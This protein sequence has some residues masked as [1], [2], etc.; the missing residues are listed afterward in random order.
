MLA[1]ERV[2]R[3]NIWRLQVVA[4]FQPSTTST[5][6]STTRTEARRAAETELDAQLLE[7]VEHAPRMGRPECQAPWQNTSEGCSWRA[8]R[9]R[10]PARWP[11]PAEEQVVL[12]IVRYSICGCAS[13][14]AR[15][16]RDPVRDLIDTMYC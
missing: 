4:L 16:R 14:I 11:G 7:P 5:V 10:R 9:W 1:H 3:R 15:S 2:R 8:A 6:T 12:D 13:A